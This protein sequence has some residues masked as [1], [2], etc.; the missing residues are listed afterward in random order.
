[1]EYS[2]LHFQ[3]RIHRKHPVPSKGNE[4]KNSIFKLPIHDKWTKAITPKA[5]SHRQLLIFGIGFR[6]CREAKNRHAQTAALS[7]HILHRSYTVMNKNSGAARQFTRRDNYIFQLS[8]L[9]C[10][11]EASLKVEPGVTCFFISPAPLPGFSLK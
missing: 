3:I 1:M 2:A 4:V 11:L 5:R 6:V 8:S 7:G 10:A 9:P